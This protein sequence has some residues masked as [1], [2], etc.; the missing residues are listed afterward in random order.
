MAMK[1]CRE[2][3]V[4][5]SSK[6]K[7]CPRCGIRGPAG[8]SKLAWV[9]GIFG[10]IVIIFTIVNFSKKKAEE[11]EQLD[12]T[13]T[14][15]AHTPDKSSGVSASS[16]KP[17][18]IEVSAAEMVKAY[19]A[20][21]ISADQ[22]YKGKV[23][24]IS[25]VI[26]TIGKD[27]FDKP[28]VSL[29]SKHLILGVRCAF[30]DE[31]DLGK[32]KSGNHV[33]LVGEAQGKVMNVMIDQCRLVKPTCPSLPKVSAISEAIG[34][35]CI[36][37][38]AEEDLQIA[39]DD[40]ESLGKYPQELLD[41]GGFDFTWTKGSP[42]KCSKHWDNAMGKIGKEWRKSMNQVSPECMEQVDRVALKEQLRA[43]LIQGINTLIKAKL[44]ESK[45][46]AAK[47]PKR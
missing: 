41:R 14:A 9:G 5:V 39:L 16:V 43:P 27:L 28:F 26:D 47:R 37:L 11:K 29:K 24:R 19:D 34:Q 44:D 38:L 6:A 36:V 35:R 4:E 23:V 33:T 15:A 17:A 1:S 40:G 7:V 22:K 18:F 32:L 3:K 25:G 46:F 42:K 2:C 45:N 13:L 21:E 31:S 20:N 10:A 8:M 30:N 12:Q